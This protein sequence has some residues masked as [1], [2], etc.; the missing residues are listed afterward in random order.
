M[1]RGAYGATEGAAACARR[2]HTG[3]RMNLDKKALAGFIKEIEDSRTRQKGET[4]LQRDV[5]KRAKEKHFDAK[6]M[7][8]VLQ[9]R[10]MDAGKR[11]EQ[12]YNVHAY[13]LALGGKKDALEALERGATIREAAEAGGISTGAAGN[14]AQLV[15]KPVFV[16]GHDPAACGAIGA[17]D[18]CSYPNCDCHMEEP[19][20]PETG[21][22]HEDVSDRR[23]VDA[24]GLGDSTVP[25][26]DDGA[27][28]ADADHGG[29][30]DATA[31]ADRSAEAH[32]EHTGPCATESQG[33]ASHGEQAP[34]TVEMGHPASST[35]APPDDL[36]FP[37]RL[38]RRH[39]RVRG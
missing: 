35:D 31:A 22:V 8:I 23:R 15:Q 30:R 25:V 9:R 21:E 5:F 17:M 14:L 16:D 36:A 1:N 6:A 27:S 20:D 4:E 19:H 2:R 7:R 10:V 34:L 32:G 24:V 18:D 28:D 13:E 11:D 37:P 26:P 12:D 39:E 3:G 33:A 29:R 38:D